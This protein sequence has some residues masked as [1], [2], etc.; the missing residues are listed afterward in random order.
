MLD[1]RD[2]DDSDIFDGAA[3]A[4]A[5][6]HAVDLD[7]AGGRY[8]ISMASFAERVFYG[9]ADLQRGAEHAGAR[10]GRQRVFVILEAARERHQATGTV[11]LREGLRPPSGRPAL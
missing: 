4:R 3:V 9:V 8:Q 5:D 6:P 11:S 1:C 2:P 10:P 7:C